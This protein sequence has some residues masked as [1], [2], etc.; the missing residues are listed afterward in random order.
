MGYPKYD[1]I[2]A[3]A[4]KH[5]ITVSCHLSRSHFEE[6]RPPPGGYPSSTHDSW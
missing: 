1:P 5:D 4:T 2:W 3:A 6:L